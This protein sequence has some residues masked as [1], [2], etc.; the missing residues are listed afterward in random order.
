MPQRVLLVRIEETRM[1]A[2]TLGP[3]FRA[4]HD[5]ALCSLDRAPDLANMVC[6]KIT[7]RLVRNRRVAALRE[8]SLMHVHQVTGSIKEWT[9]SRRAAIGAGNPAG[10]TTVVATDGRRITKTIANIS[11]AGMVKCGRSPTEQAG[12]AVTRAPRSLAS[13]VRRALISPLEVGTTRWPSGRK[14]AS[15]TGA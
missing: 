13:I 12:L 10:R 2:D 6:D 1:I 11:G 15:A 3:Q 5:G 14:P 8:P 4:I 7:T 9:Q